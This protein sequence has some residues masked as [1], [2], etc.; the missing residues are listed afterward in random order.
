M[1]EPYLRRR[2]WLV[3]LSKVTGQ[4]SHG[5]VRGVPSWAQAESDIRMLLGDPSLDVLTTMID[6]YSFPK[7]APGMASR[8]RGT[9]A[10]RV[11]HVEQALVE[12]FDDQRLLP[13]LTLYETVGWVFT[14]LADAL[15]ESQLK[16]YEDY[17]HVKASDGAL[18]LGPAGLDRLRQE[19]PHVDAWLGRFDR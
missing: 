5:Y 6:Y 4:P 15:T 10:V 14:G 16:E 17:G 13:Y 3:T 19:N 1:L 2:G 11:R 8:P 9:A 18:I 7:D 12:H